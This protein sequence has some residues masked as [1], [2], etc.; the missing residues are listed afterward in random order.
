MGKEFVSKEEVKR[1]ES[2][3][4]RAI[5]RMLNAVNPEI[6]K[7]FDNIKSPINEFGVDKFGLDPKFVKKLLL[8]F[9]LI[10]Y[11]Y[12]RVKTYGVENIPPGKCLFI[13]NHAGQIPIDASMIVAAVLLE[14]EPPRLVRS[15]VERFAFRLPYVSIFM[16]RT[17]QIVG[18]PDNCLRLL[19]ADES[20]LVFP[21]G[22]RGISKL[23]SERYK[24]QE[25]TSG[26]MRLALISG[27]PI[28]PVAVVGSEEQMPAIAN[29]RRLAKLLNMPAFPITPT[30]PLLPVLGLFPY[31]VKYHIYFGEP[32]RFRGD[33][34]DEEEKLQIKVKKVKNTIQTMLQKGL[35]ERK[36]IFW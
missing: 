35:D 1:I 36:H 34:D 27:A 10:Y 5:D 11:H 20:I 19:D 26:F 23:F 14:A 4:D 30:H 32:I 29:A 15:M 8:P 28:V 6:T 21:E 16:Q 24:L 3:I 9:S 13:A 33:P 25:F 7:R 2:R 18:T 12:F 17:G 31:P 22:V